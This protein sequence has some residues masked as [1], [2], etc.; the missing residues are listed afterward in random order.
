MEYFLIRA[1]PVRQ[2]DQARDEPGCTTG[3]CVFQRRGEGRPFDEAWRE[4]NERSRGFNRLAANFCRLEILRA[5]K[6]RLGEGSSVMR[7]DGFQQRSTR[8]F[9]QPRREGGELRR[10][11]VKKQPQSNRGVVAQR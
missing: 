4:G 6:L 3:V 7:A 11:I 5:L 8:V 1:D 10:Q 2:I 9:V